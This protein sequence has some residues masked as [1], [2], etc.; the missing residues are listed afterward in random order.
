M[1]AFVLDHKLIGYYYDGSTWEK[2][3]I[4]VELMHKG[5]K[6]NVDTYW[7][8]NDKFIAPYP[9]EVTRND[10]GTIWIDLIGYS[11]YC[12]D[13]SLADY[14]KFNHGYLITKTT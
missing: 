1:K 8:L 11:P 3:L 4:D 10:D 14:L 9:L 13:L 2:E 5:T 12:T 6:K 7:L